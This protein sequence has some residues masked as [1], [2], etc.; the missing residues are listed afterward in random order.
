M[1]E[2]KPFFTFDVSLLI[3]IV[4]GQVA[5]TLTDDG[6]KIK[7]CKIICHLPTNS[8]PHNNTL[9]PS[10]FCILVGRFEINNEKYLY[11]FT[12]YRQY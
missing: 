10:R 6:R 4:I 12:T 1:Q 5:M 9:C 3:F 7:P 2:K 11:N 8:V